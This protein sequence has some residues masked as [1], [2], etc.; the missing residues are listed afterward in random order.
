MERTGTGKESFG[1][2]GKTTSTCFQIWKMV[3][4]APISEPTAAVEVVIV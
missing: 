3:A 2:L 1:D 4:V